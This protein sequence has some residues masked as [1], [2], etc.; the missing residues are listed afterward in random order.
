MAP[1]DYMVASL[2]LL[3]GALLA[4][5]V[6]VGVLLIAQ[7]KSDSRINLYG[8]LTKDGNLSLFRTGQALALVLSSWGFVYLIIANRLTEW[9]F[10]GYMTA[11]ALVNVA[12]K[13]MDMRSATAPIPATEEK[14][15]GTD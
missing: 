5:F 14:R 2:Y 4:F 9:F 3:Q 8:Y 1:A 7:H 12:S 15:D 6:V 10:I 11:W 13:A